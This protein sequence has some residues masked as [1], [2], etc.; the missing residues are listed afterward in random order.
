MI[1]QLNGKPH[2]FLL[3]QKIE[4]PIGTLYTTVVPWQILQ[5]I[6]YVQPRMLMSISDDGEEEYVG[7]QR[8]LSDDR[9]KEIAKY[10]NKDQEATFPSS[11]IIN[12]P[13]DELDILPVIPKFNLEINELEHQSLK[14]EINFETNSIYMFVFPFKK[15]VAQ[16]I[17]GQHRMSGFDKSQQEL[18]FELPV[19]I[20]VD[21]TVPVQADIFATINGKQTRVTPSLVYDLFGLSSKRSP[22]KVVH[23]IIKL[24]NESS[25]SP[26][27]AWVRILGKAN[28]YYAG[29]I[30]QSTLAKNILRLICGNI[31]Q[32]EEDKI[33]LANSQQIQLKINKTGNI[34]VLRNYFIN[35]EDD[36][37][38]KILINFFNAVKNTYP[39]EWN[40]QYSILR[41]TVGITAL[42]R[43]FEILA[44]EG[45]SI[46]NLTQGFF[47]AKLSKNIVSFDNIQLSSKGVNQ[48]LSRFI[49]N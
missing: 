41:K 32:A 48:L 47:E 11:I 46:N 9:Q 17:D 5:E 30:T 7:I 39:T 40:N 42:F 38:F 4:Q 13:F 33:N 37:L 34:P 44:V 12:I 29:S 23:E 3:C 10:V 6:A 15:N 20:F 28:S 49:E 36:I 2:V 45:K 16:I 14:T 26:L 31:K 18:V 27:K 24:L 21:Q 35:K 25:I 19:T 43:L 22:Y 1:K 8:T